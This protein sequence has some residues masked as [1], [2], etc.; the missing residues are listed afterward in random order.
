MLIKKIIA[1]RRGSALI[2]TLLIVG[3][4]SSLTFFVGRSAVKEVKIVNADQNSLGAYYAA[5]A[6]LEDGL[7]RI[8]RFSG[9]PN[10]EVPT[11]AFGK[12][13]RPPPGSTT[14]VGDPCDEDDG[15][16]F[17]INL[18]ISDLANAVPKSFPT[19]VRVAQNDTQGLS[20]EIINSPAVN[21]KENNKNLDPLDSITK[22]FKLPTPTDYVYDL[23]IT[24]R[25]TFFGKVDASG[26][27]IDPTGVDGAFI[28]KDD[29]RDFTLYTTGT[30]NVADGLEFFWTCETPDIILACRDHAKILQ[31]TIYRPIPAGGAEGSQDVFNFGE[32]A[33][34]SLKFREFYPVTFGAVNKVRVKAIGDG[35]YLSVAFKAGSGHGY[36]KGDV[37]RLQSIGYHAGIKRRL[38][39]DIDRRTGSLLGLF[40]YAVYGGEGFTEP[41]L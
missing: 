8:S 30:T 15:A 13:H 29:F 37:A 3:M 12:P 6:G 9:D 31:F 17:N 27:P 2:F 38:E 40:D 14:T 4:V 25:T 10:L 26:A 36:F 18:S 34:G 23:K 16:D 24:S 28:K 32:A 41:S 5:E 33:T 20:G 21:G 7:S 1:N 39:A 11:C 22:K 19:R 35:A